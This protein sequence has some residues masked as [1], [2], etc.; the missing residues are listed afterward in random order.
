VK[1][2]H[3][4]LIGLAVHLVFLFFAGL[5]PDLGFVLAGHISGDGITLVSGTRGARMLDTELVKEKS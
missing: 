5:A 4:L 3:L 1:L 2:E